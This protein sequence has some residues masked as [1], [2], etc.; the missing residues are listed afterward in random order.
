MLAARSWSLVGSIAFSVAAGCGGAQPATT[1]GGGSASST[2]S[3]GATTSS[4]SSSLSNGHGAADG[5]AAPACGDGVVDADEVCNTGIAAGQPGACPTAC[6]DGDPCTTDTLS[7]SSC[8]ATCL[9][10]PV[11]PK[12]GDG[13]CPAGAGVGTD[14]DCQPLYPTGAPATVCA[15]A[16]NMPTIAAGAGH[17]AVGCVPNGS[18]NVTPTV[19]VLDGQGAQLA[20]HGLLTIDGYYYNEVQVSYH[21]GRFQ[22]L[23]QYNCDDTGSWA[24]GWGWGCIDF[25]QLDTQ[26]GG[27]T[28]SLVFGEIGHNGHPVLDDSGALFGVGWVSYDSLYFRGIDQNGLTGGDRLANV[29][30]GQDPAHSDDRNGARTHLA[31]DGSAFGLFAV[32]GYQLYFARVGPD[33]AVLTPLTRVSDGYSQTFG[34]Q[35]AV[36]ARNGAYFVAYG[37]A[38]GKEIDFV[39][40]SPAGEILA[41]AVVA[42]GFDLRT[43][44]MFEVGGAFHVLTND[45]S[46]NAVLTVYDENAAVVPGKGGVIGTEP[47]FQPAAAYDPTTGV[48]GVVYQ[49]P[50]WQGEVRFQRFTLAP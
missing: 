9:H 18:Q 13:C 4:S 49:V 8:D 32:I 24:V 27:L 45:A 26:G 21:G 40:V 28:P 34:G 48:V 15:G 2:G 17:F 19:Q 41:Q 12:D 44:Q 23:Y 43:A 39:K 14:S 3:G 33:G 6:D 42:S 1:G 36:A 11:P 35:F 47:M 22:A 29:L 30:V 10:V 37:R 38:S 31:W 46:R 16:M 20:S 7:G 25:R 50:D 5:G